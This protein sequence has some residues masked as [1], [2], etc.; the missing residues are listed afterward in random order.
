MKTR[1]FEAEEMQI[2]EE[3]LTQQEFDNYIEDV[4]CEFE[5]DSYAGKPITIPLHE[6]LQE[7]WIYEDGTENR[8]NILY[9]EDYNK[10]TGENTYT[11][12][13]YIR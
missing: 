4:K 11:I 2:I 3:N 7:V 10:E 9:T 13:D 1:R 5:G 8:K 12:Y 6:D